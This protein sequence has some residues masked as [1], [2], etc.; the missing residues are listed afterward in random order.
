VTGKGMLTVGCC[1][2]NHVW[3]TETITAM[4]PNAVS[5]NSACPL[6][7]NEAKTAALERCPPDSN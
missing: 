7:E 1:C 6:A 2:R 3:R 4:S 5:A